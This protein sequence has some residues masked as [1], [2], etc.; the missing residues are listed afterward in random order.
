MIFENFIYQTLLQMRI[1]PKNAGKDIIVLMDN[2]RIHKHPLVMQTF[3][4][5]RVQVIFNC[6]YSPWLNPV[7]QLFNLIKIRLRK[8]NILRK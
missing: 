1:D 8:E 6:E 2:A 7:E 5:L 3:R 4:D